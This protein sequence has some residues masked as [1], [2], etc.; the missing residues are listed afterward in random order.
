MARKKPAKKEDPVPRGELVPSSDTGLPPG[1]AELLED[2]KARVRTAQLKA[3]VAVNREMTQLDWDIGRQIVERQ[4]R[5]GW[6]RGI[7]DRLAMDIQKAF[8]GLQGFSPR[9]SGECGR[10]IWRIRKK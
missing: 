3:A 1:Y 2:F 9:K 7:V 10:F 5:E 8:P 4:E 6:G